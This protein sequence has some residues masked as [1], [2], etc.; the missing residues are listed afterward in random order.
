[1]TRVGLRRKWA[2]YLR[3]LEEIANGDRNRRWYGKTKDDLAMIE[4]RGALPPWREVNIRTHDFQHFFATM[5][6]EADVDL[7]TA[8]KWM[9]H[10][11]QTMILK[12]YAHLTDK[13]EQ[14]ATIKMMERIA[15]N[16]TTAS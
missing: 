5:L 1:M 2:S 15:R 14:E 3:C 11:D 6:R 13:K 16:V 9:G 12:V 10:A 7:K 4:A 8:M